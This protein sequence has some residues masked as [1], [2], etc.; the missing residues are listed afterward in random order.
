MRLQP[1]TKPALRPKHQNINQT[2]D[3]RRYREWQVHQRGEK[4]F[5]SEFI[6]GNGP[7][8]RD[9]EYQVQWHCNQSGDKGEA[10]RRPCIRLLQ[11]RPI[12]LYPFAQ[13]LCENSSQRQHEKEKHKGQ[14]KTNQQELHPCWLS[15]SSVCATQ[16]GWTRTT[17][18]GAPVRLL[19]HA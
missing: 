3:H 6:L 17:H 2:R 4:R 11:R 8:C 15:C 1:R 10:N 13:G 19:C 14:R 5:T 18:D 9:T 16:R 7:S 12:G